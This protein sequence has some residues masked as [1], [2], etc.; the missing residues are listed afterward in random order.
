MPLCKPGSDASIQNKPCTRQAGII[1][2]LSRLLAI[3]H[4]ES[5]HIIRDRYIL[6]LVV[7][8][9]AFLLLVLA[10]I[11]SFDADYFNL[12]VWDQDK[13]HLSRQYIADLTS[14]GTFVV[15]Y[16]EH[17]QEMD[18]WLQ[19]GRAHVALIIPPGLTNAAQAY[20]PAPVQVIEDG[21]DTIAAHQALG[22][23]RARTNLF[24]L[25]LMP[26]VRGQTA[27]IEIRSRSLYNPS[28]KSLTSMVPGL[29]AIVLYMPALALAL[30]LTREKELGSFEGLAATPLQGAEYLLGKLL[31]YTGFGLVSIL[32]VTL[33]ATLWFHVPFRGNLLTLLVLAI[34]Y[35]LASFGLST[36]VA[37]AVKS[38]QAVMLIMIMV[39][40]VPSFFLAGLILPVEARSWGTRLAAYSLPVSHF[41]IICRGILLKGLGIPDLIPAA[42]ALLSIGGITLSLS[43]MLFRKWLD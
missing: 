6:F 19:S 9:P 22:Q 16:V 8:A 28:L 43:L 25:S 27:P 40:F 29:I 15:T 39:F 24:A 2:N 36:I 37:N 18:A 21:V 32:P 41:I 1:L 42:L 13:S 23:L 3:A 11:F 7:I 20:R 30:S 34:C 14:D 10:Y 4:K 26:S 38:Q 12:V 35:F 31:T 17:A 33:V 5:R